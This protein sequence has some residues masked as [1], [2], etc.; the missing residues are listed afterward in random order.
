MTVDKA[1]EIEVQQS[2]AAVDACAKAGV[3]H[4]LYSAL[5]DF[6]GDKA[7]PFFATKAK[8]P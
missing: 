4:I 1:M 7:V 8:G 2:T 6:E 3:K 5:T